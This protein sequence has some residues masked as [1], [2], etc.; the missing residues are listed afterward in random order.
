MK[1]LKEFHLKKLD[2]LICTRIN[3]TSMPTLANEKASLINKIVWALVEEYISNNSHGFTAEEKLII[4]YCGVVHNIQ[5]RHLLRPFEYMDFSRRVGELWQ[6]FC[7]SAWDFT[8]RKELQIYHPP[9]FE[10]IKIKVLEE[11]SKTL[12]ADAYTRVNALATLIPEINLKE[13]MTYTINEELKVVDFKSGFGSNEKGNTHRLL[14]VANAY[15]F[16]S[17]NTK[18]YLLVRQT[19]NNNYLQV[20]AN[21]NLWEVKVNKVAYDFMATETGVAVNEVVQVCNDILEDM[22]DAPRKDLEKSVSG[23]KKYTNWGY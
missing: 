2:S 6:K 22:S 13:D 5:Q 18:C 8:P 15:K 14:I 23:L 21:S 7:A 10:E 3:S 20:L 12:E 4:R 17:P 11:L 19:E 9:K 16:I 1:K